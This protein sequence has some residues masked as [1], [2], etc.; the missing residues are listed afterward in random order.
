ML[1]LTKHDLLKHKDCVSRLN[2]GR[3]VRFQAMVIAPMR[4]KSL[5]IRVAF[6]II[7]AVVL[8]ASSVAALHSG[9]CSLFGDLHMVRFIRNIK[10]LLPFNFR[11]LPGKQYTSAD[12]YFYNFILSDTIEE[13]TAENI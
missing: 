9:F 7:P 4:L 1:S 13:T 8:L 3:T 11:I 2:W 12:S 10:I 5:C 6:F